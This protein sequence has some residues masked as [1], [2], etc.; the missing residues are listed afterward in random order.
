[1]IVRIAVARG[2]IGGGAGAA[3]VLGAII[4]LQLPRRTFGNGA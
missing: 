2:L 4:V 1:M 3:L